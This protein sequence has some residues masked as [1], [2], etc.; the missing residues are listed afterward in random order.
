MDARYGA[1]EMTAPIAAYWAAL[2][3]GTGGLG[4]PAAAPVTTGS[5]TVQRFQWGTIVSSNAG[6]F[7]MLGDI[8]ARW[9]ATGQ[10]SGALGVPIQEQVCG[11][12]DGGC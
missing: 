10:T 7:R 4:F 11:T 8:N 12:K 2:G 3:A 5:S 6:I 9:L 1:W